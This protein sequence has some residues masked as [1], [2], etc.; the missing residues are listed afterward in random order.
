MTHKQ[1]TEILKRKYP[2]AEIYRPNEHNGMCNKGQFAVVF[3]P[4][5]KV[6][7]YSACNYAEVLERLGC[8]VE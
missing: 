6:Y 2:D 3:Q 4:L 5:G 1:A 8:K 7:S